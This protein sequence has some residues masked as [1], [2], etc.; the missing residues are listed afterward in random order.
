MGS[1]FTIGRVVPVLLLLLLTAG[2]ATKQWVQERLGRTRGEVDQRVGAV[3]QRVGAVDQ[4]VGTVEAQ[5]G[6]H[7][8]RL[9]QTTQTLGTVDERVRTVEGR[10]TKFSANRRA[11]NLVDST[12]V[13]FGFDRWDLSDSAQTALLSIIKEL[14][15]NAQLTV[16][17]QG[18]TDPVGKYEYNV[19]LSQRRVEAVRRFLVEKGVQLPRIYAVGIGPVT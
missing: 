2:C 11:R 15:T 14:Q 13:F 7:T 4:R 16:D 12:D 3:D 5:V 8:Q 10:V 19:G 6:E 1:A 9:N 18:Y 17:L